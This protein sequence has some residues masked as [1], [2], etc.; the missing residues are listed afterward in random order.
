M[1][2]AGLAPLDG[3]TVLDFTRV[4]SG[5]YCTML[6]ADMGARVIKI[7]QPG[8]GDDTRA[9]GPPFITRERVLPQHQPEQG[10][11]PRLS[12]GGPGG[13]RP[14]AAARHVLVENFALTR[15]SGWGGIRPARA[16]PPRSSTARFR[17]RQ[18]ARAARDRL[19]RGHAGEA[20]CEHHRASDV[21]VPLGVAISD[22][23]SGMLRRRGSRWRARARPLGTGTAGGPRHARFDRGAAHVPGGASISRPAR[24]RA[25]WATATDDRPLR[26][27]PQRTAISSSP[28]ARRAVA[29]ILRN[30]SVGG[31]PRRTFAPTAARHQLRDAR[32]LLVE[33]MRSRTRREWVET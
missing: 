28:S 12:T 2:A 15:W 31:S 3:V 16:A 25:A 13:A 27:S 19:R 17:L 29:A 30:L 26:S 7:E 14:P 23:V 8:R 21:T 32:P 4:L 10:S 24:R 18:T 22:I 1:S 11:G 33:R 9:W 20:A 5:P 6:L